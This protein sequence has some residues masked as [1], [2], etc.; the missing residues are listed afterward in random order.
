MDIAYWA[1]HGPGFSGWISSSGKNFVSHNTLIGFESKPALRVAVSMGYV[2]ADDA[3]W[4]TLSQ[5]LSISLELLFSVEFSA[6]S[7]ETFLL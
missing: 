6:N 7:P 3:P 1:L 4:E 2:G 5:R